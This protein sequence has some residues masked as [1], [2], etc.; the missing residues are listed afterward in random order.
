MHSGSSSFPQT[1]EPLS[2]MASLDERFNEAAESVKTWK[3]K[4]EPSDDEKL[5]V[6]ALFKQATTGDN[7]TSR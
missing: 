6:Y 4:K 3:P 5:L 7:T 1:F 2:D